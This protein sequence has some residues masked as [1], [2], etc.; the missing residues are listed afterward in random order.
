M[1]VDST[2]AA[3]AAREAGTPAAYQPP[4]R[5]RRILSLDDFE[6]AARS[7]L[8]RPVYSFVASGA[9][10]EHSMRGNRAAYAE[11]GF[12]TRVLRDVSL[13]SQKTTL[14]GQTH[15]APFGIAPLG[16]SALSAYRGDLVLARAAGAARI[17]MVLSG[18]SLIR[19]EDVAAEGTGAW[20][21]AYL[22]GDEARTQALVERV[23][24]AGFRNLVITLDTP[25][26]A[27]RE[28]NVR[29]GFSIPL[30][31]SLRLAWDG[32][33]HPR[34]LAGTFLQTL[35][36][37]GM[38]H[39]ENN[40]ATRG[41]PILSPNVLRS[42]SERGHLH[43]AHFDQVRRLWKGNLIVKGILSQEDARQARDHGADGIIVSNHGGR[44]L[45]GAVA[46]LRVLPGI[47]AACPELPIMIDG[48]IRRGTDVLKAL[49][50]GAKFVFV[51]RPFVFAAALAGQAGV[52]HA[53]GILSEEIDRD[54]GLL[55]LNSLADLEPSHLFPLAGPRGAA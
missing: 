50:L 44:Q 30:R 54:M 45:D 43:W 20:F 7:H 27:N 31:P 42:Y 49:A 33:S 26:A 17:P 2:L 14:F 48:G 28:N 11:F 53:I 6:R 36:R 13:R 32:L 23:A 41:V 10:D 9:E 52:R 35:L 8:P 19:M 29:A 5:L 21:Q 47:V 51:G 39:F 24:R 15:D 37:H 12:V 3:G 1:T 46:P 25:V 16:L 22:P 38:P 55:G 34:W 4:Q 18:S 40:Y